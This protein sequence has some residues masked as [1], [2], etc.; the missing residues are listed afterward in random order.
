MYN[1]LELGN[2]VKNKAII[3]RDGFGDKIDRH[4]FCINTK[5][6]VL[7][8]LAPDMYCFA[9]E[10]EDVAMVSSHNH[11]KEALMDNE[12]KFLTEF[13]YDDI[14]SGMEEGFF[15]VKKDNKHGHI[16]IQGEEI[17]PCIYDDGQYFSEGIAPE[18]L[19]GKWGCIDYKNQTVLPFEYEQL[20]I[21]CNNTIVAQ[22]NGKV[23]IIDKFNNKLVDFKYDKIDNYTTRDCSTYVAKRG[24]KYGLI[25]KNG[26]IIE[27]FIYDFAENISDEDNIKGE[28]A[29]L[30][31]DK[32]CAIYSTKDNKFLTDFKYYYIEWATD[33]HFEVNQN[34]KCGLVDSKGIEV[35][36][37]M[38]KHV[39]V[40]YDGTLAIYQ[41]KQHGIFDYLG[42]E[43]IPIGKYKFMGDEFS[44]GLLW[45]SEDKNDTGMF[46]N[47]SGK[48]VLKLDK[49]IKAHRFKFSCGLAPVWHKKYGDCYLDKTGNI[50]EVQI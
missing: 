4:Y 3:R 45:V 12:G 6:E 30:R 21:C 14:Y 39:H 41:D 13:I 23:G 1:N 24:D 35:I 46:I 27:P 48:V 9:Y 42:K 5:G 26:G 49:N 28:F 22:Y 19:N 18:S 11:S 16:N 2:F 37:P 25:D 43:I 40:N 32:K 17:I 36:P 7:F 8:D 38:Y 50:V 29:C 31:K 10:N 47:K 15:V 34:N 33:N 20:S 44:E